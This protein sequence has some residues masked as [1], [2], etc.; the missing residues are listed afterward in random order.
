MM[1]QAFDPDA[2]KETTRQQ[3]QNAAAAWDR[4][5]P[6]LQAWLGPVT[7][8]MLAMAKLKP[9][10][11]VLDL[12]AGAGEPSISAAQIVGPT[13]H[14]LATDISSNILEFAAQTAR[15][16]GLSNY[17][18]RVMDG[19]KPDQADDSFAA[20]LSRLGLIYFPDRAGALRGARRVLQSG[21]RVVLASFSTPDHNRF[22]SIPITII[23]RRAGLAAPAPGLPGPFS[24]GAPGV[25]EA[26]LKDGGFDDVRTQIVQPHL[27]LRS[28]AECTRFER[29]SFGALGQMLAALPE[30]EQA[31]A[32]DEIEQELRA[33]E[34]EGGFEAPTE[35][36]VGAGTKS[37]G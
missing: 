4:W 28:A 18:T 15:D 1:T 21:G 31:A 7:E 20:V 25:M 3:W 16:R 5:T 23:R 10:D 24:L 36:V 14:V 33:F 32:W 22:F 6:T 27:K 35:L 29:E 12:A 11:R 9:G 8:A 37:P 34:S 2:Y 13:G 17:E 26:M 19:E 30:A